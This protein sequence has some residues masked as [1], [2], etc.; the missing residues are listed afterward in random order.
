MFE[1]L[2]QTR[3][4]ITDVTSP[5][6]KHFFEVVNFKNALPLLLKNP[7]TAYELYNNHQSSGSVKYNNPGVQHPVNNVSNG[8]A[9]CKTSLVSNCENVTKTAV[10]ERMEEI[11][12]DKMMIVQV[13][14]PFLQ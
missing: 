2:T 8:D 3:K 9:T 6:S 12:T 11:C 7:N 1:I 5:P 10:I 4:T 14:N 13:L